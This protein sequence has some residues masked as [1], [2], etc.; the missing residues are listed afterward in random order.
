[1]IKFEKYEHSAFTRKKI[2]K[3]GQKAKILQKMKMLMK[4]EKKQPV[5]VR[6]CM[7]KKIFLFSTTLC[8]EKKNC[9]SDRKVKKFLFREL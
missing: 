4:S 7:T 6:A 8:A 5:Y 9:R 2:N 3:F 1:M